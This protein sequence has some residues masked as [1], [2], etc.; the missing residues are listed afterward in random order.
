MA[1]VE[2][3][4]TEGTQDVLLKISPTKKDGSPAQVE[5]G[6]I[7]Y[8]KTSGE[9]EVQEAEDEQSARFV[10]AGP[11]VSEG[12]VTADADLGEGVVTIRDTWKITVLPALAENVGL[13]AE[14]V[15]KEIVE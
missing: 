6:S 9:G 12:E 5:P 2:I 13:T 11:G 14:A 4:V 3:E 1:H 10:T 7:E 15:D 8:I